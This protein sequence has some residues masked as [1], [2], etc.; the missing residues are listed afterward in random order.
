MKVVI[1]S[2]KEIVLEIR[3]KLKE[4]KQKYGQPYCPCVLESSHGE[5]TICMCKEFRE[6]I[7]NGITGECHCGLY[8]VVDE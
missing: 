2:D 7:A 4:N 5:N 8:V 3:K 6:Q 1:N